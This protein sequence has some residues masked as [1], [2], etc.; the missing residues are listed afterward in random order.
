MP[1]RAWRRQG[2]VGNNTLCGRQTRHHGKSHPGDA[3]R[4]ISKE[5]RFSFLLLETL[6]ENFPFSSLPPRNG[7]RYPCHRQISGG[8]KILFFSGRACAAGSL[9]CSCKTIVESPPT[10]TPKKEKKKK[11]ENAMER[12]RAWECETE[13][14][15]I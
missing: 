4:E 6:Q 13:K 7:K 5:I 15:H 14:G 3:P 11:K 10:T 12:T 9:A 2:P 1:S 8:E